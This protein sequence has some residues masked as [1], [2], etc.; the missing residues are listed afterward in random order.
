MH[1]TS[2]FD[3]LPTPEEAIILGQFGYHAYKLWNTANYERKQ[4]KED[5]PMPTAHQQQKALKDNFFYKNLPSQ[6]AQFVLKTLDEGWKSYFELCKNEDVKNPR[7]PKYKHADIQF[8]FVQNAIQVQQDGTV[9]LSI[10]KAVKSYVF[11]KHH[12]KIDFLYLKDE[13]FKMFSNIKQ[14]RFL[15]QSDGT[16]RVGVVY[17]VETPQ[18]VEDNGNYLFIDLG[19]KNFISAYDN[20]NDCSFIVGKK[21]LAIEQYYHKTI[22]HFQSISDSQQSAK[23]VKYPKQSKRVKKLYDKKANTLHDYLHKVT[24]Y[25]VDYCKQHGISKVVIGDLTN[26]RK[27]KHYKKPENQQLHAWPFAKLTAMLE[28]KLALCGIQLIKVKEAHSS[29]CSPFSPMVSRGYA[30]KSNRKER[31]AYFDNGSVYNADIVGAY[32]IGR[33]AFQEGLLAHSPNISKHSLSSP[34]KVAV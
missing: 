16:Y 23:G 9:R 18:L 7:P 17:E 3:Y 22:A 27:G 12:L 8:A 25:V 4:L 26:I 13:R 21:Y 14:I 28:Y 31:G 32:N 20:T 1:L 33:L 19:I 5:E 30:K 24:R 10:P 2:T 34:L 29:S 11:E 6:T 15:K